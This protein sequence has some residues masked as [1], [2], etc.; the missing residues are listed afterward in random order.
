MAKFHNYNRQSNKPKWNW[1]YDKV[2]EVLRNSDEDT[3]YAI[4]DDCN[5]FHGIPKK[6]RKY[7]KP[8]KND[9]SFQSGKQKKEKTNISTFALE[10]LNDDNAVQLA[11]PPVKRRNKVENLNLDIL[12]NII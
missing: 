5:R 11:I 2:S 9:H 3:K 7:H 12:K 10:F 4:I 1:E 6:G 8:P